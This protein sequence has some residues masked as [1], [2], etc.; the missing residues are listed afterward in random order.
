MQNKRV[1]FVGLL[2]V[3]LIIDKSNVMEE[4]K[5]YVGSQLEGAVGHGV[6]GMVAEVWQ[7]VTLYLQREWLHCIFSHAQRGKRMLLTIQPP[8]L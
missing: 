5:G 1:T 2:R 6:E 8:H 3:F 7:L 4:E